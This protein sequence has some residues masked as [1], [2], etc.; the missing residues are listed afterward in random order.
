MFRVGDF[1]FFSFSEVPEQIAL[2][3]KWLG[4]DIV[5]QEL[6]SDM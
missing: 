5:P 4:F 3:L 1:S 2:H 6:F